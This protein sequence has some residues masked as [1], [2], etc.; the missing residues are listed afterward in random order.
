MNEDGYYAE[1]DV[2][3]AKMTKRQLLM[4]YKAADTLVWALTEA[5]GKERK[6]RAEAE[7]QIQRPGVPEVGGEG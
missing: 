2:R 7:R 3:A 4:R 5:L 6:R 1:R